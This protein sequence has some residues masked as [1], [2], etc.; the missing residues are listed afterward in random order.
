MRIQLIVNLK[1]KHVLRPGMIPLQRNLV[2]AETVSEKVLLSVTLGEP[3][4]KSP[5][6]RLGFFMR[7]RHG[8]GERGRIA[9][10]AG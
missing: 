8:E 5:A 10:T 7:G 1:L 2:E 6:I 4:T 3:N 9:R